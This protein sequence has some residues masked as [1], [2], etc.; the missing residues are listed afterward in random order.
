MLILSI[1]FITLSTSQVWFIAD[2]SYVW[3]KTSPF[4]LILC[5]F[6]ESLLPVSTTV[7]LFHHVNFPRSQRRLSRILRQFILLINQK[8]C[9]SITRTMNLPLKTRAFSTRV[10]GK[11]WWWESQAVRP[12]SLQVFSHSLIHLTVCPFLNVRVWNVAPIRE[13]FWSTDVLRL[14]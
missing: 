2:W 12:V 4:C 3:V 6:L 14:C 1:F 8:Y 13:L 5:M 9:Q 10:F 11:Q 7:L